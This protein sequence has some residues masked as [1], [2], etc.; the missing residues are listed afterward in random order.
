MKRWLDALLSRWY[1]PREHFEASI[2]VNH[3]WEEMNSQWEEMFYWAMAE[4][5]RRDVMAFGPPIIV[6]TDYAKGCPCS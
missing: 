4:V 2:A 1:V 6:T 5:E 3:R